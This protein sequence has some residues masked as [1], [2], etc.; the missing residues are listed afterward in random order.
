MGRMRPKTRVVETGGN[1][2]ERL[3]PTFALHYW[4]TPAKSSTGC[5]EFLRY[6][7]FFLDLERGVN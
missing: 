2:P 1:G 6:T 5:H 4:K 7:D 3:I